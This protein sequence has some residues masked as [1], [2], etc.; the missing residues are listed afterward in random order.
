[1]WETWEEESKPVTVKRINFKL[2]D[3]HMPDRDIWSH[4][5][6]SF[7]GISVSTDGSQMEGGIGVEVLKTETNLKLTAYS[8]QKTLPLLS[9]VK[10]P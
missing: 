10:R 9:I 1:M 8:T 7:N 2:L 3:I 5:N 4:N 6:S